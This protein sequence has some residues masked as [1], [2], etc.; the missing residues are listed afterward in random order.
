MGDGVN[1]GVIVGLGVT[2]AVAVSVGVEVRVGVGVSVARKGKLTFPQPAENRIKPRE[3]IK[4][5]REI[6]IKSS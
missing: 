2:V 3:T 6:F 4:A 5:K 1:V